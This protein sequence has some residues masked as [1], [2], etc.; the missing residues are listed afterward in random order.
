MQLLWHD[1]QQNP[2]NYRNKNIS[3]VLENMIEE[4]QYDVVQDFSQKWHVNED[5]VAY[6]MA[7]YNPKRERQSGENELKRSADYISYKESVENPLPKL[8]YWKTVRSDFEEVMQK[9]ILP[10]R[11]R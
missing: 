8:R 4:T 9:E 1:L 11:D 6:V 10:L 7:N 5:E 3:M 2:E